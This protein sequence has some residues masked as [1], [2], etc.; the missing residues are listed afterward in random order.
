MGCFPQMVNLKGSG[1]LGM[2]PEDTRSKTDCSITALSVSELLS[3]SGLCT[4]QKFAQE[5]RSKGKVQETRQRGEKGQMNTGVLALWIQQWIYIFASLVYGVFVFWSVSSRTKLP[6]KQKCLPVLFSA[7]SATIKQCPALNSV[8][9]CRIKR[10]QDFIKTPLFLKIRLFNKYISREYS[11]FETLPLKLSQIHPPNTSIIKD[12]YIVT[13][14]QRSR[15][16]KQHLSVLAVFGIPVSSACGFI[17][18]H[19]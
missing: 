7:A 10:N 3:T 6:Q 2:T 9:L 19:Y 1:I 15:K 4:E 16:C 18:L 5:L 8:K 11:H 12:P 17:F 13:V 14:C